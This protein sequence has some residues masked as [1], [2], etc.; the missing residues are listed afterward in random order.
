MG[1]DSCIRVQRQ[2]LKMYNGI[3][4]ATLSASRLVFCL[5]LFYVHGNIYDNVGTVSEPSHNFPGQA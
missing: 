3:L 2:D 4:C 5:L 1:R